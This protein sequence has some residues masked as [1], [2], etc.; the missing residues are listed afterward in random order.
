MANNNSKS[1]G[2]GFFS[3]LFLL[4]LGLKLT[5]NIDWSWWWVT[6]PLWLPVAIV[7]GVIMIVL[8][9]KD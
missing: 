1:G 5:N 3:L 4:F 7:I 8:M 2:V 9:F 6:S